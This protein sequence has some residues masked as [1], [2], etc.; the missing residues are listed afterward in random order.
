VAGRVQDAV[1]RGA[2]VLAGGERVGRCFQATLLALETFGPV[3][4]VEVVADAE[5][6]VR[7]RPTSSPS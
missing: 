5:A 6:A 2:K 4:S 1:A 3:A 7:P